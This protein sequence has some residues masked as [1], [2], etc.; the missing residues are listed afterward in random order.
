MHKQNTYTQLKMLQITNIKTILESIHLDF[1]I[2]TYSA[3]IL[4]GGNCKM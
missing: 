2:L 3:A 1:K 4:D